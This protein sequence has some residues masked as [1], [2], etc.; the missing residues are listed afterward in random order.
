MEKQ[1]SN[2]EEEKKV[3]TTPELTVH[4]D[5]AKITKEDTLSP[6]VGTS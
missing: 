4:G 5:A 6:F 3:W 2:N 1:Q